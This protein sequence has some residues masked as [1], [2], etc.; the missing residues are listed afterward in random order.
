MEGRIAVVDIEGIEEGMLAADDMRAFDGT[1]VV[2]K[3]IELEGRHMVLL[4]HALVTQLKV[5]IPKE[6]ILR[7]E[8]IHINDYEN[9]VAM[10]K[11]V[12]VMI[13]DDSKFLRF[14]LEKVLTA[15]G[16]NV[17]GQA[18]NGNEAVEM[19]SKLNPDVV[20]MDIEM[21]HCDGISALEPLRQT[22]PDAVVLMISSLGEEEKILESLAKGAFDF[23][24]KPIDPVKTVK[25]VI[26]AIIIARSYK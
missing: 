14:K 1:I 16:L 26:N 13:V 9:H 20:T 24:N 12:R 15:A 5:F 6:K 2:H 3:G 18:V 21:P 10:L 7:R 22:V 8:S 19:A 23:I 4:K 11:T 17:V 25:A